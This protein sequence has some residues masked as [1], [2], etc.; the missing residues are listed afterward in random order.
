MTVGGPERLTDSGQTVAMPE[1]GT[2]SMPDFS[3][4]APIEVT[5]VE[6]SW[7]DEM[8]V[9]MSPAWLSGQ[10][11]DFGWFEA[12]PSA[13]LRLAV[14]FAGRRKAGVRWL[15]FQWGVWSSAPVGADTERAFLE[16]TVARARAEGY[17]AITQPAT[18]ALFR[19]TPAGAP[20]APFGTVI[21]D[22]SPSEDELWAGIRS[23][24][25]SVT[26][27]ATAEGVTVE[28][29]THLASE[30]HA[31]C[32]GTMARS[33]LGFPSFEQFQAMVAALG[34]HVHIGVAHADGVPQACVVNPWSTFGAHCLFAG[35]IERPAAGAAT[36][37][38]WE[39]IT[40]ARSAGARMY[41][42]V[43]VRIDPE[44]GSKYAGM[45][46]FKMG[47]GGEVVEGCLWKM[48]LSRWQSSILAAAKR[49]RGD[50]PDI[51]D[52]VGGSR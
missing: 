25:R 15:Q 30:A 32:A 46:Q 12:R 48:P 43:G 40:R 18:M 16:A 1:S 42:L 31:L 50:G 22:L 21:I 7:T 34:E 49:L 44:P 17:A 52:Q 13:D 4:T 6:P 29:G 33:A 5:R 19:A 28:W 51:I 3:R 24:N 38:Q 11:S 23:R 37:L 2:P 27:K 35:S 41:D 26:R 9:F 39:A 8:P 14:P 10:A 47:F 20:C 36:L 45:R